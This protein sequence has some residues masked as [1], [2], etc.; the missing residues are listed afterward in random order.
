M[1]SLRVLHCIPSLVGGGAERQLSYLAPELARR[2][3]DVYVAYLHGG[4]NL[5]RLQAG[6]VTLNRLSVNSNYHPKILLWLVR[7][8]KEL[9]PDVVHTWLTQMDVAGGMAAWLTRTA[10]VISER[11]SAG[12]YPPTWKHRLRLM[13]GT[14]AA[15]ITANSRGGLDYWR[16]R[17]NG[18]LNRVIRNG[19]PFDEITK[20]ETRGG[21][22]EEI[23]D[24]DELIL[25]AGRYSPE[26]NLFRLLD[27]LGLVLAQRDRATAVLFGKGVVKDDLVRAAEGLGF[28]RRLRVEDYTTDL[29][30][31]LK[32]ADAF[33]LISE[34]E[35][36]PN[37]V[38]EAIASG[39]PLVVSD[40]PAHREF[41]DEE[42]A[43][44]VRRRDPESIAR[45]I[46]EALTDQQAA[47]RKADLAR[48]AIA[49]W[50]VQAV[51]MEYLR[52]Y[53]DL[54]RQRTAPS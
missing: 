18:A 46:L 9:R 50:S 31:W 45:G 3:V 43:F 30:R 39:C 25:F 52:L 4:P 7:L 48:Q 6:G 27:A 33:V 53:D 28:G 2:G 47:A 24:G 41:L 36:S 15:A 14:R 8:I 51:A 21:L 20:R 42:A 5:V 44:F 1:T 22:T 54:A 11:S 29:W 32:R 12:A 37:A 26:K 10:H 38:I 49:G 13:I 34:F 35:G 23:A 17:N 19:I 40:I 16:G